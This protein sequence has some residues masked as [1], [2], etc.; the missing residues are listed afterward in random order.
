MKPL[1]KEK[2]KEFR[3]K[4]DLEGLRGKE[5]RKGTLAAFLWF[6]MPVLVGIALAAIHY[7]GLV[8]TSMVAAI[9][10]VLVMTYVI[11]WLA[12]RERIAPNESEEQSGAHEITV[13]L[14]RSGG[15]MSNRRK[16]VMTN[17]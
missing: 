4:F 3:N 10:S 14:P 15:A 2:L 1:S 6:V 13:V 17:L 8:T 7:G 5:R 12:L 11:A 16:A 9:G